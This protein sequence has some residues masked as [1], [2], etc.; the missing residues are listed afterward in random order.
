MLPPSESFTR[1]ITQMNGGDHTKGWKG[2]HTKM[3]IQ[4]AKAVKHHRFAMASK[5]AITSWPATLL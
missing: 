2:P 5:A 4:A 1:V 3:L